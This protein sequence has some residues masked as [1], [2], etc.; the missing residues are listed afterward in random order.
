MNRRAC[1]FSVRSGQRISWMPSSDRSGA[2]S[3]WKQAACRAMSSRE[4]VQ[5]RSRTSRGWRPEAERVA[6]PV[7]MRRLRPADPDHEELVE[8]RG[9]DGEE[10]GPLQDGRGRVLG[11]LQDPFVEREPAAFAVQ[12]TPLGQLVAVPVGL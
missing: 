9:E 8:V 7:A 6:T 5:I 2:M 12:E 10:V 4:R 3:C 1:S 11:Q